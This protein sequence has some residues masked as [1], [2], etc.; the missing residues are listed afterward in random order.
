MITE[1]EE[2]FTDIEWYGVDAAGHVARFLTAGRGYLPDIIRQR[3]DCLPHIRNHFRCIVREIASSF[4]EL[5]QWTP[6]SVPDAIATDP[7]L[8]AAAGIYFYDGYSDG[9]RPSGYAAE[10]PRPTTPL[11]ASEL[12]DDIRGLIEQARYRKR[13]SEECVLRVEDFCH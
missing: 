2:E 10:L 9:P 1:S 6:L 11:L 13:F 8:I 12:P 7:D 4:P 3:Y 5:T